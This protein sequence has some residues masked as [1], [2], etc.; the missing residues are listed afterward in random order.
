MTRSNHASGLAAERAA[1]HLLRL[2]GYTVLAERRRTPF[3]EIDLI[4]ARG[5]LL[6]FTEVKARAGTREA[7]E[8][9]APGQHRARNAAAYILDEYL[10]AGYEEFRFDAVLVTFN[11]ISHIK[12]VFVFD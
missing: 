12:N 9:L 3:G 8:A 6:T 10:A 1:A 11:S 5:R 7:L 2:T 4:A